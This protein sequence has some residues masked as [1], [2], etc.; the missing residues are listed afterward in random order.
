VI[1]TDSEKLAVATGGAE[2]AFSG[3]ELGAADDEE[4]AARGDDLMTNADTTTASAATATTAK[5]TTP[6][7]LARW[8]D[9]A[10]CAAVCG[11]GCSKGTVS[12]TPATVANGG[13]GSGPS[14]TSVGG[15]SSRFVFAIRVASSGETRVEGSGESI[16]L[17]FRRAATN[18]RTS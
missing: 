5:T 16:T 15:A 12:L 7:R 4:A 8:G 2:P 18:E 14:S 10:A 17:A 3:A 11:A 9:G 6:A 13:A 1:G